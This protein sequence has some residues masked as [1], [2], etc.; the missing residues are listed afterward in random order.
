MGFDDMEVLVEVKSE[1]L[2]FLRMRAKQQ[3][4][5]TA[6]LSEYRKNNK[7]DLVDM[8]K[9]TT[10][11]AFF[12]TKTK[13]PAVTSKKLEETKQPAKPTII[14]PKSA[15]TEVSTNHSGLHGETFFTNSSFLAGIG[16]KEWSLD[17]MVRRAC[18]GCFRVFP[19]NELEEQHNSYYCHTCLSSEIMGVSL[20]GS[21]VRDYKG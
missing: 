21:M 12:K 4:V 7:I 16:G 19:S 15:I 6:A 17:A 20:T 13:M 1:D 3:D 14:R 11:E 10:K 9:T 18:S 8:E 5:L 2:N